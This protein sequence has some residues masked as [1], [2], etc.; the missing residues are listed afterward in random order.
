MVA[1]AQLDD[2]T[3]SI[4]DQ[5]ITLELSRIESL[6]I[7]ELEEWELREDIFL[8]KISYVNWL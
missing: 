3:C 4:Q 5:G 2:I 7:K 6:P 1:E 8:K